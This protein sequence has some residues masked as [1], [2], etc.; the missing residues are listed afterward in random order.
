MQLA[1]YQ[2]PSG[3]AGVGRVLDETIRPLRLEGAPQRTLAD[4]LEVDHG[5]GSRTPGWE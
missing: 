3:V 4:L 1:K 5:G 2:L